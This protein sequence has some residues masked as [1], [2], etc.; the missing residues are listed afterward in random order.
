MAKPARKGQ[1]GWQHGAFVK[2]RE[3]WGCSSGEEG[4]GAARSKSD[5]ARVRERERQTARG[6]GKIRGEG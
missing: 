1:S 5:R 3:W 4:G 2:K 6:K